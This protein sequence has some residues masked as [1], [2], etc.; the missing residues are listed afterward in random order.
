MF[1]TKISKRASTTATA[2]CALLVVLFLTPNQDVFAQVGRAT[3]QFAR[4]LLHTTAFLVAD[5]TP[6][7]CLDRLLESGVADGRCEAKA[8]SDSCEVRSGFLGLRREKCI[9]TTRLIVDGTSAEVSLLGT[10]CLD[11]ASEIQAQTLRTGMDIDAIGTFCFTPRGNFIHAPSSCRLTKGD[12]SFDQAVGT[13][14]AL[15]DELLVGGGV[16]LRGMH[17]DIP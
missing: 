14:D 1:Q 12:G 3:D 16:R 6:A 13:Y 4:K 8:R 5:Q 9:S 7:G 15:I 17:S 11:V 2:V 10:L